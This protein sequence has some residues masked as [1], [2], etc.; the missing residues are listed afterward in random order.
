MKRKNNANLV[1]T[2]EVRRKTVSIPQEIGDKI[3]SFL[4]DQREASFLA[5]SCSF[6]AA[7]LYKNSS[8]FLCHRLIFLKSKIIMCHQFKRHASI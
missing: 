2:D 3:V 4:S 7:V 1:M 6:F 8:I 5:C